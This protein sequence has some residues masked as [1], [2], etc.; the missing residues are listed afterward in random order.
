[1]A[2]HLWIYHRFRSA[3]FYFQPQGTSHLSTNKPKI[4]RKTMTHVL[5][6]IP[7]VFR[8]ELPSN[9]PPF[10]SRATFLRFLRALPSWICL[11]MTS[12]GLQHITDQMPSRSGSPVPFIG[13]GS[14]LCTLRPSQT[15]TSGVSS[16]SAMVLL[17]AV[18]FSPIELITDVHM[19]A[20]RRVF[21][22]LFP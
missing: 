11:S 16:V 2:H 19:A 3:P 15:T 18:I 4:L 20:C 9:T 14:S 7:I 12:T 13:T 1:M 17:E 5:G 6:W 21:A 10:I 8:M 22:L